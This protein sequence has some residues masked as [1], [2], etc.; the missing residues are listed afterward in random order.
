M[1]TSNLVLVLVLAGASLVAC[2]QPDY[3]DTACAGFLGCS[4]GVRIGPP[5]AQEVAGD[6][7]MSMCLPPPMKNGMVD[8]NA[9]Y[10]GKGCNKDLPMNQVPTKPGTPTG[11]THYSVMGTGATLTGT[12]TTKAGERTFWV[13]VPADYDSTIPY[14]VIYIGQGCG[15][16]DSANTSTL[17][18]HKEMLGGTEEAIYVALDIPKDMAN[19]D[20]YD[21]R[22]GKSS[23]EWEAFELFHNVV[24]Q[25]YCVD[26]NRV[27]VSGYSTGGWLN[28]MWGCY[29]AGTLDPKMPR[30]FAPC[31]HIR[32]QMGVTGGEPPE[33]PT[34][35]GPVA[36]IWIHDLNDTANSIDGNKQ[37]LARVG[38][39]NGCD[40]T[41]DN[42]AVQAPWHPEEPLLKDVCKKFTM[43]PANYPVVFCT[44]AGLGH[45]D[46]PERATRAFKLFEDE[47]PKQ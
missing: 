25:N 43:C 5:E 41:Y 47:I 35:G 30:R 14:P 33:Q 39:M 28:N 37:A 13:R 31:Y 42:P 7:G 9:P 32:A 36:A 19:M 26:N 22:D 1:K 2:K 29:F 20:C 8:I 46:Q 11:Y 15:G 18:L 40:T 34:C 4:A 17:P 21:N 27:F 6:A 16:Y 45:S 23:Q 38:K 3:S 10:P 44:S 12:I 24:D